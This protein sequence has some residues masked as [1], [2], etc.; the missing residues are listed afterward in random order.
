MIKQQ[1]LNQF[2][3]FKTK[4]FMM[5]AVFFMF[6]LLVILGGCHYVN[7][8]AGLADDNFFEETLENQLKQRT[9][10]DLDFTPNTPERLPPL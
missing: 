7:Q 8:K 6:C 9:G 2:L 3:K 5:K 1:L 10:L 4:S